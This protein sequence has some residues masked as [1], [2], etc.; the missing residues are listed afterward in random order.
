[1]PHTYDYKATAGVG[2]DGEEHVFIT[3]K[4]KQKWSMWVQSSGTKVAAH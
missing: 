1:M 4:K 3:L 2:K